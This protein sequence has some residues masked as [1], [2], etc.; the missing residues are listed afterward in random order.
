MIEK[1]LDVAKNDSGQ[2]LIK[3]TPSN[4]NELVK[5]YVLENR[6]YIEGKGFNLTFR[7]SKDQALIMIDNDH[8]ETVISNLT[9]NAIKYCS[10]KKVIQISVASDLKN[11]I[12]NVS[13]T[14]IGIP[15]KH[16]KNI[17]KKFYRVE[18]SLNAKTKGHGLGLSIVQNLIELNGGAIDVVSEVG[19]GTTFTLRFP[20]LVK[21]EQKMKS[22]KVSDQRKTKLINTSEYA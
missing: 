19:K 3:A 11:M 6:S 4:L 12:L 15:R 22:S 10:D 17:F 16:L 20:I 18:D 14:G 9:E 1:L 5:Q 21:D 2:T 13:D 8:F 7:N